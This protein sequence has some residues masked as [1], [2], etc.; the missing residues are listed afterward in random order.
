MLSDWS[1]RLYSL[2]NL[3]TYEVWPIM[4][5]NVTFCARIKP[6]WYKFK[7]DEDIGV[8]IKNGKHAGIQLSKNQIYSLLDLLK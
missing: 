1:K 4:E 7:C 5:E 2:G 6:D 3:S 8:V